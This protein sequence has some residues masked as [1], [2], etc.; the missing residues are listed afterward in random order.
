MPTPIVTSD[1]L[2]T[3][4]ELLQLK[5]ASLPRLDGVSVAATLRGELGPRGAVIDFSLPTQYRNIQL[6]AAGIQLPTIQLSI[7]TNGDFRVALGWPLGDNSLIIQAAGSVRG[8]F[9]SALGGTI[10]IVDGG[11]TVIYDNGAGDDLD[12]AGDSGTDELQAGSIVI[13][14]KGKK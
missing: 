4:L 14:T 5:P 8:A 2:P 12:A 11:E 7:Y 6:G 1:L 13:H 3:L 10:S 9:L